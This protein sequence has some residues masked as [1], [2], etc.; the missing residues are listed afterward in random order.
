MCAYP[1][2]NPWAVHEL[3]T[4]SGGRVIVRRDHAPLGRALP[5]RRA[6]GEHPPVTGLIDQVRRHGWEVDLGDRGLGDVLLGLALV[7]A[8][9]DA[10]NRDDLEYNGPRPGL[11]RR[12]SLEARARHAA[13]RH[14]VRTSGP[15]P[16]RFPAVPEKP[17]AW[18]DLLDDEHVEVHAALPMRYYL[19]AEQALG[20]RL[21]ASHAPSPSFPSAQ[22]AQP[23]HV[24]FVAATSWPDRKDYGPEGFAAVAATLMRRHPAPWRFTLVT[25]T[26][27]P[28][29]AAVTA[30]MD[31]RRGWAAADCVDLFA[32][33]E[34][35]IGND[36][37]LTHLAALTCRPDGSSPHVIGLY[38][39]HAYTKWSTGADHH[40]AIATPFSQMLA[41]ADRCPVRDELDD[42]LWSQS[43]RLTD[44]PAG[45]VADAT[46]RFVGWW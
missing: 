6:C 41:A 22:V 3:S 17:P 10:T 23:F 8:L 30:M 13:G 27:T 31:V 16:L 43:A 32:C 2:V 11:V 45:L 5:Y 24:V 4:R 19:D 26:N 35:V 34:I 9:A 44:I 29:M 33:A 21:P 20:V 38:G 14:L 39:R 37:G 40:H 42:A 25:G 7:R 46:A 36:T 1:A 12:S 28:P 15:D 18:L